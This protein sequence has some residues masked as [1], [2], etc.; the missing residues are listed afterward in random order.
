MLNEM[1]RGGMRKKQLSFAEKLKSQDA[2]NNQGGFWNA[3]FE[4]F[5]LNAVFKI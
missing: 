3:L 5:F 4:S 2:Y 1:K